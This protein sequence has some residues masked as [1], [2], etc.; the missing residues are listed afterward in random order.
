MQPEAENEVIA[1]W[2]PCSCLTSKQ[3]IAQEKTSTRHK[4]VRVSK[5][6][7][8]YS[9]PILTSPSSILALP[10]RKTNPL[11]LSEAIKQ[12]ASKTYDQH[13][14]M[15]KQDLEIIDA[16]RRG[17]SNV[18][19]PH[20]SGIMKIAAYAGQLSWMGGK[21]PI[22]V[23]AHHLSCPKNYPSNLFADWRRLYLVSRPGLQHRKAYIPK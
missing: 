23:I 6:H 2:L 16:L 11:T 15:F 20:T 8:S 1:P 10:F 22:D 21:F 12:Y 7:S 9:Y 19:E 18:K 3:T 17:A 5:P 14:D 13:P 4:H